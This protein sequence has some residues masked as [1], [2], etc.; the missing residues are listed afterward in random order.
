M[1][2]HTPY[3][4][5]EIMKERVFCFICLLLL[6]VLF[7]CLFVFANFT[8]EGAINSVFNFLNFYV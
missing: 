5:A 4:I 6:F 8:L 3:K 1:K 2:Q 7:V